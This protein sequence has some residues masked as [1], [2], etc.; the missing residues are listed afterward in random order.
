MGP[1]A[2]VLQRGLQ[3]A[4][5]PLKQGWAVKPKRITNPPLT[6]A[7]REWLLRRVGN[8]KKLSNTP[9]AATLKRESDAYFEQQQRTDLCMTKRRLGQWLKN[10]VTTNKKEAL[11]KIVLAVRETIEKDPTGAGLDQRVA[12]A[13]HP[14]AARAH[15]A[16]PG[17][18]TSVNNTTGDGTD[19]SEN[20]EE[21]EDD[22]GPAPAPP[23][24]F[25]HCDGSVVDVELMKRRIQYRFGAP[26][27][28]LGGTV[29]EFEG[30]RA[31]M[32]ENVPLPL[33]LLS[34]FMPHTITTSRL[35]F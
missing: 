19:T 32:P 6:D 9:P 35:G 2:L 28:W 14:R 7:Q 8:A 31:S 24:G 15:D 27:G 34:N 3:E 4:G 33:L 11:A 10:Y 5:A 25:I 26:D 30:G 20:E 16:P 23:N 21:E 29:E 1:V 22:V 18:R 17:Q 12:Q 13:P